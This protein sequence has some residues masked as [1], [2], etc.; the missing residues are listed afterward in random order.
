M[1]PF[2]AARSPLLQRDDFSEPSAFR[3]ENML[4]E[5]RRQKGLPRDPVP[6]V[7]LLD[8]DGDIVDFVRADRGARPSPTWACFHTKLWEWEDGGARYG[9]IGHAVGASFAVLVAEQAF[10]SGC[11]LLVSITSAGQIRDLGPPPYH[12]IIEKALR[13]EGTSY[14]YLPPSQWSEADPAV[15]ALAVATFARSRH[16]VHV[17]SSWTTD[18]PFRETET[19]IAS[20]AA[21]GV[22]SVEMEASAL[23]AFAR[24]SGHPVLCLAHVT[25]QL[26]RVENDFEKGDGNGARASLD[27]V[28]AFATAWLE[29]RASPLRER[30]VSRA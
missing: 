1:G 18:A 26:G 19:A 29:G 13:D 30:I 23:Y 5:A 22:A 20:R 24:S 8:P 25:N 28:Q 4:R 9:V 27:L 10:V 21:T 17:G 11:Q 12:I 6:P 14:H 7:C 2:D 16:H 15:V 3:P